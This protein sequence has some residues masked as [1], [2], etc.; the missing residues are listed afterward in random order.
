MT[1]EID[2]SIS[3]LVT[4]GFLYSFLIILKQVQLNLADNRQI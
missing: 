3:I 4:I 2:L 1:S